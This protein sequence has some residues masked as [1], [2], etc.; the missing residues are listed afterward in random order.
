MSDLDEE[1]ILQER[2][3]NRILAATN[4]F[5]KDLGDKVVD[6]AF[7]NEPSNESESN[8]RPFSRTLNGFI[9]GAGI[10]VFATWGIVHFHHTNE[11]ISTSVIASEEVTPQIE[12]RIAE[13]VPLIKKIIPL[14]KLDITK[15]LPVLCEKTENFVVEPDETISSLLKRAEITNAD[16]YQI[17]KSLQEVYDLRK[18]QPGDEVEICS[19]TDD[20]G[21]KQATSIIIE[22]RKGNRY[23]T[24]KLAENEYEA[25]MIEPTTST[26]LEKAYGSITGPFIKNAKEVGIPTNVIQQIISA[27]DGVIDFNRD[28]QKNDTFT[29]VFKKEYNKHNEPTG[30]GDLLYASFKIRG[31]THERFKYTDSNDKDDYY[32]ENGKIA[33]K[34]FV[35]HPLA[36]PRLTSRFG[37]RKHPILGYR[38]MHWGN[39]YGAPIGTPVRAPGDGVVTLTARRGSYG[40][41]VEI[42]H[43]S[44]YSTGYAHMSKIHPNIYKGKK[45]KAGDIIGYVGNTGRSTGPHLHWELIRNGQ[46]IDPNRQ[47]ITSN[48]KLTGKELNRYKDMQVA[49]RKRLDSDVEFKLAE[50]L[51]EVR[52]LA[53][54]A[55]VKKK[56]KNKTASNRTKKGNRS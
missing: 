29:A 21:L 54:Q 10:G 11:E 33:R 34:L 36:K 1:R 41:L 43:N 50:A 15:T 44:E 16:A 53:Y 17:T 9:I 52:K 20:A 3:I 30:N 40:R 14:A 13:E 6:F 8:K 5:L 27:F 7:E 35:M 32:D 51:P 38:L 31:E 25:Q 18:I 22:D 24:H 42:K 23:K 4:L 28:I 37:Q 46:K 55:P 47:R 26:Q 49:F 39:D 19:N 12:E 2:C 48:R 56:M 45:V